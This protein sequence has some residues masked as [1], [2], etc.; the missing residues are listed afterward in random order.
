MISN[1]AP[2]IMRIRR[3]QWL[4]FLPLWGRADPLPLS[5]RADPFDSLP[6]WGR[7]GR[8]LN[9]DLRELRRRR[10]GGGVPMGRRLNEAMRRKVTLASSHPPAAALAQRLITLP[11]FTVSE[12]SQP[13][14]SSPRCRADP[15]A[16][17]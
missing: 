13:Y 6:L 1:P 11:I 7:A 12:E 3:N 14:R 8:G 5:G 15:A 9:E 17:P 2:V 4:D 16:G 10:G